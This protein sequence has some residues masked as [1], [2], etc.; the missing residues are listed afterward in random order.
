VIGVRPARAAA[1]RPGVRQERLTQRA[2]ALRNR[3]PPKLKTRAASAGRKIVVLKG[4]DNGRLSV[5]QAPRRNAPVQC[6][7]CDRVV[8]RTSRNQRFCSA[9]CRKRDYEK[10]GRTRVIFADLGRDTRDH[11]TPF[12][13]LNGFKGL[14]VAKTRSTPRI[15]GPRHVI[16]AELFAGRD[17]TPTVSSDGVVCMVAPRL[18]RRPRA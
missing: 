11:D 2:T 9:R 18:R 13:K 14:P 10:N 17:W 16:D 5:P 15:Y 12:Q 1:P 8:Q 3:G 7:V 4:P 6:P